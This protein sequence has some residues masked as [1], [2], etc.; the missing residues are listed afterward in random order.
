[1]RPRLIIILA[2]LAL[3]LTAPRCA[4][5]GPLSAFVV[6]PHFEQAPG[7]TAEVRLLPPSASQALG[8]ASIRLWTKVTNPNPFGFTLAS[9]NATLLLDETRAAASD[10][11]LGLPLGA[12]AE[13]VIPID[14]AIDFSEIPQL[15]GAV[16]NALAGQSIPFRLEGTIGVDAGRLGTPLFGPMT[17]VTGTIP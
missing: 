4:S 12:R 8:G 5:L 10:F 16:R 6:P 3:T 2:I 15:V 11:P 7:R 1:M 17:I 9:V 13:T 14:L